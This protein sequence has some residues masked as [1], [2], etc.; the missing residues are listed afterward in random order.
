[1]NN[2]SPTFSEVTRAIRELQPPRRHNKHS[3]RFAAQ[4]KLQELAAS[5]PVDFSEAQWRALP[6]PI[7]AVALRRLMLPE[8]RTHYT[9]S[10]CVLTGQVESGAWTG[11]GYAPAALMIL[12]WLR[13]QGWTPPRTLSPAPR[14]RGKSAKAVT[15]G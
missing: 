3:P 2:D 5:G 15:H 4:R 1:M 14:G 10:G 9:F 13:R 11:T 8:G 7:R 6:G 12:Q